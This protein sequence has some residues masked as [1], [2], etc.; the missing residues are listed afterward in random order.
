MIRANYSA[1]ANIILEQKDSIWAIKESLLRFDKKDDKPYVE[2]EVGEQKFE[3]KFLKLGISDGIN[4]EILEGLKPTDKIKIWNK[5]T[6][7]EDKEKK[8]HAADE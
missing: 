4:V 7:D 5:A 1:N 6:K 3:K 8:E 2:V